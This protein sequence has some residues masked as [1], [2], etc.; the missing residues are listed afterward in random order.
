MKRLSKAELIEKCQSE[1]YLWNFINYS[2]P[3]LLTQPTKTTYIGYETNGSEKSE[4]AAN[5]YAFTLINEHPSWDSYPR[6]K[7]A[8]VHNSP[9]TEYAVIL[10]V[11]FRIGVFSSTAV[12]PVLAKKRFTSINDFNLELKKAVGEHQQY[13]HLVHSINRYKMNSSSFSSNKVDIYLKEVLSR[14][15]INPLDALM[16]LLDPQKNRVSLITKASEVEAINSTM[17]WWTDSPCLLVQASSYSD[18]RNQLLTN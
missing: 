11:T 13:Q 9:K 14:N 12:F 5:S 1:D 18:I 3:A 4:F 8:L 16:L 2:S 7:Y 6:I 17:T 15:E 10:P